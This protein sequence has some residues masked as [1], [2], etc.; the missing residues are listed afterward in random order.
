MHE[1]DGVAPPAHVRIAYL[2]NVNGGCLRHCLQRG[3]PWKQ[4]LRLV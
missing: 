4:V 2:S 3:L 1:E